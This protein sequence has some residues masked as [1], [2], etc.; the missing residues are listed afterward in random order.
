MLVNSTA[1]LSAPHSHWHLNRS[2]QA[3]QADKTASSFISY[4]QLERKQIK[5]CPLY[6][7]GWQAGPWAESSKL[8]VFMS[9][10]LLGQSHPHLFTR[11]WQLLLSCNGRVSQS[12]QR[13]QCP[14]HLLLVSLQKKLAGFVYDKAYLK[15]VKRWWIFAKQSF[16]S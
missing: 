2:P 11:C 12:Q 4:Q 9:K 13:P 6:T 14:K 10:D 5:L 16:Y 15:Y 8:P 3:P 7:R 1:L